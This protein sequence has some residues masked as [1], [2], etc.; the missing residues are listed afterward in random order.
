[1]HVEH[2]GVGLV[3]EDGFERLLAVADRLDVVALEAERHHERLAHAA[4]VLGDEDARATID[5]V[6]AP[7]GHGQTVRDPRKDRVR[8]RTECSYGRFTVSA[9]ETPD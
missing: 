4:V 9:S 6:R 5:R 2:H 3:V 1:H 7:H 8:T